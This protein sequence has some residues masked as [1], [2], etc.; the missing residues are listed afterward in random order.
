MLNRKS[1]D[2][3]E[4]RPLI[5]HGMCFHRSKVVQVIV[6]K[7]PVQLRVVYTVVSDSKRTVRTLDG[8]LFLMG[9]CGGYME[10]SH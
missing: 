4:V 8:T 9:I 5:L 3:V 6:C 1:A 7:L 10:S 2:L